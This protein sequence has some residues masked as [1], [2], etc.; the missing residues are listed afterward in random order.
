MTKIGEFNMIK[1][2]W[3]I[4]PDTQIGN[5]NFLS[6]NVFFSGVS[7]IGNGNLFGINSA[8]I[9]GVEVGNHNKIMA[10]MVLDKNIANDETVFYRHK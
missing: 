3:R 6:P 9:L 8:T 2:R 7:K 10:G 1:A 4:G 5:F